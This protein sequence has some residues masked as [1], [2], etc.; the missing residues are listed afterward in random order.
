MDKV[1]TVLSVIVV[2]LAILLLYFLASP[3]EEA[4][5]IQKIE[6]RKPST[7][8]VMDCLNETK[9][10]LALDLTEDQAIDLC[11]KICCDLEVDRR[12]G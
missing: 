7:E 4:K 11:I 2:L 6:D 10:Q 3:S 12:R 5:L 9:P 8:C 1:L